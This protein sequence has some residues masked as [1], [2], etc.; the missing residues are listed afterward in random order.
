MSAS[1]SALRND[2]IN[3]RLVRPNGGIDRANLMEHGDTRGM[4]GRYKFRRISPEER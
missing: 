4:S 3:S 1:L 2:H